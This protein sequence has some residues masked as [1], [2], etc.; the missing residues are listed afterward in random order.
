MEQFLC[1]KRF[2]IITVIPP[3]GGRA[4]PNGALDTT[5]RITP[6]PCSVRHTSIKLG[7]SLGHRFLHPGGRVIPQGIVSRPRFR[8]SETEMSKSGRIARAPYYGHSLRRVARVT[9]LPTYYSACAMVPRTVH[10]RNNAIMPP[11]FDT[12]GWPV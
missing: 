1:A 4:I 2:R 9:Y 3:P 8:N 10:I 12:A 5:H 7:A 6:R 11:T